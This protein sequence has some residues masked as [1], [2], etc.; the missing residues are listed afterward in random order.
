MKTVGKIDE[1]GYLKGFG[2]RGYTKPKCMLELCAN[3]MDALDKVNT[4][5]KKLLF[6]IKRES[7]KMIENGFG[8]DSETAENMFSMHRENHSKDASRGVSG[9]GAKPALSNLSNQTE[10]NIY[11]HVANG[12]YI[13]ITAPWEKIH[14]EGQYTNMI[15]IRE[16]TDNEKNEY[17]A[18]REKYNML[19]N[20][21]AIGTT[22]KFKY[23][24][25]L[26]N[27]IKNNFKQVSTSEDD[28]SLKDP[29]DRIGCVFGKDNV[30]INLVHYD[31]VDIKTMDMYDYFGEEDSAYYTGISLYKIEQY[32][33][34]SNDRFILK[35][36]DGDKEIIPIGKGFSKEPCPRVTNM[37]GYTLVGIYDVKVG[38]RVDQKV[39]DEKNPRMLTADK[40]I[41]YNSY[42]IQHL[43]Q[44]NDDFLCNDKL[45]RNN[46]LINL[47]N[48]E[49]TAS[50]S[51][52]DG[53]SYLK[54]KLIQCNVEF[55]PT[56]NQDNQQDKVVGIQENKNQFNRAAV[57]KNFTRLI[58]Y[59]REMKCKEIM[60]YFNQHLT[61]SEESVET[62]SDSV[63]ENVVEVVNEVRQ[64]PLPDW[65]PV[66]TVV[67]QTN[68]EAP[69]AEAEAP[70][71]EAPEPALTVTPESESESESESE[72]VVALPVAVAPNHRK[73][74]TT[75]YSGIIIDV[76]VD[77]KVNLVEN[78][79]IHSSVVA[80]GCG[81]HFKEIFT[82]VKS[83]CGEEVLKN[84]S[85]AIGNVLN[86]A[87]MK[88]VS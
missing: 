14:K 20:G 47:I 42:N 51:R 68:E 49:F 5:N 36:S 88:S 1:R 85:S 10:V 32:S 66:E 17:V 46:Q 16:M 39:F 3:S 6:D 81:A 86:N 74:L 34:S 37:S 26:N 4:N 13:C 11:S 60:G 35:T 22:I 76:C 87:K 58:K 50:S 53:E 54:I 67:E 8:M 64:Q 55:Y 57:P 24:D 23:N 41:H 70:V 19:V 48:T 45:F 69:V 83:I 43:G 29:V 59:V 33:S 80:L 79:I 18:E 44:D 73:P 40:K 75:D 78:G 56:S 2:R 38:L 63:V 71:V 28:E 27:L 12:A 9:I 72:Q 77:G 7:I 61:P 21:E 31:S 15:T 65:W 25:T 84:L 30:D 82:A 52:A 62:D